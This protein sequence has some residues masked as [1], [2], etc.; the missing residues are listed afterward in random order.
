MLYTHWYLSSCL[1]KRVGSYTNDFQQVDCPACIREL[2]TLAIQ[3]DK[4]NSYV[5]VAF[6]VKAS[7]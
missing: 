6:M 7:A 3:Q 1:N 2:A 4:D 5:S